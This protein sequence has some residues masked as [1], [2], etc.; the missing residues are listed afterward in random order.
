M[1]RHGQDFRNNYPD[2]INFWAKS[3]AI[4]T[5]HPS[6]SPSLH[7]TLP[8][9]C[10]PLP[11]RLSLRPHMQLFHSSL[12]RRALTAHTHTHTLSV[13]LH[14]SLFLQVHPL[15]QTTKG[16]TRHSLLWTVSQIHDETLENS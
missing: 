10:L 9:V 1:N 7:P 4:H 13:L 15:V 8:C 12:A 16:N 5:A 2:L 11:F 3:L 6:F 14:T